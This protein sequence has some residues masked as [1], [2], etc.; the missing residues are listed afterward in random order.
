MHYRGLLGVIV[1]AAAL[2][3][4]AG[5]YAFDESKYPD[6]KG[7]WRGTGGNKWTPAGQK[8]PLTPE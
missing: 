4:S 7:M 8:A 5:A 3:A 2:S 6:L 1:T